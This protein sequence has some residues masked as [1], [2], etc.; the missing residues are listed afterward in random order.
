MRARVAPVGATRGAPST[1][2]R[3]RRA[4]RATRARAS[5]VDRLLDLVT[6]KDSDSSASSGE[7]YDAWTAEATARDASVA[8]VLA[9]VRGTALEGRALWRWRTTR[10]REGTTRER[11]TPTSTGAGRA[12]WS[13]SPREGRG[14]RGSIPLGFY[15]VG[16][17]SRERERVFVQ[18]AERRG[19]SARR[20]AERRRERLAGGER[21]DL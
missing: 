4:R 10:R 16:G 19:V 8:A 1:R 20:R 12:S 11:F 7:A 2:A 15:S 17:L 3:A 5:F 13:G 9:A 18:V 14:S 21:G 6:P